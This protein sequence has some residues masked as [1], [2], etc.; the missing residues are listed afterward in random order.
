MA[1]EQTTSGMAKKFPIL[2][3]PLKEKIRGLLPRYPSKR[4][5]TLPALHLVQEHLR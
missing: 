2:S 1:A 5:V 4:A 3:E